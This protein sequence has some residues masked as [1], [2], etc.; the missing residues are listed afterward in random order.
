[1]SQWQPIKV[2]DLTGVI[3]GA[4][5]AALGPIPGYPPNAP[6]EYS[7]FDPAPLIGRGYKFLRFRI[8]FQL[9]A[10]QTATSPIPY[11]DR[12]ATTFQYNF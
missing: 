4:F 8:F 9:D 11:V 1:M 5:T 12:I 3:G 10:T 2:H 6:T 7:G